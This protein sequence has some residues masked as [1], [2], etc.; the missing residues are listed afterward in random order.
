MITQDRLWKGIIEDLFEDF[1]HY[2]RPHLA[3]NEVDFSKGFEFMDKDL[4]ILKPESERGL[5]H[6]DKL[7]KFY[8][9]TGGYKFVL[10]H[11]EVQGYKDPRFAERMFEYYYRIRDKWK[12]PVCA[13]VLYTNQETDF[14]PL[15]YTE[16]FDE[17]EIL[18]R[19]PVFK[20]VKKQ[21]Q[22]LEVKGN[23]FSIVLKVAH[24][25]LQ[26]QLLADDKQLVWKV[27]LVK[28]LVAAGFS[29]NKVRNILDF[30]RLYVSFAVQT[31]AKDLDQEIDQ[32]IKPL[33]NMGLQEIIK[34]A[35][36]EEGELKGELKSDK[37]NAFGML[38]EGLSVD[39]IARITKLPLETITAWKKEWEKTR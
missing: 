39:A 23:P 9:K 7:I 36:I 8:T 26:K 24:K 12:V 2:F 37:K 4:D 22:D 35:Y 28:Q 34:E 32:L 19:F 18:Y 16:S 17:T 6:A 27:E 21:E 13:F 1:L 29:T 20:L 3:Q 11:V 10:L 5:R 15:A 14:Q 33:K 38:S 25:A 31:N 30:I